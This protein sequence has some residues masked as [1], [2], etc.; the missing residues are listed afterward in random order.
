MRVVEE[1]DVAGRRQ[2]CR[3]NWH[4]TVRRAWDSL[5]RD[6]QEHCTNEDTLLRWWPGTVVREALYG[7]ADE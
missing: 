4:D 3:D 1:A 7:K 2:E 5:G 6:Q